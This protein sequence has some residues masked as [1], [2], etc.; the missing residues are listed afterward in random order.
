ME[1]VVSSCLSLRIRQKDN[2][3]VGQLPC[4]FAAGRNAFEWQVF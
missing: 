3:T 2:M 4:L 1:S